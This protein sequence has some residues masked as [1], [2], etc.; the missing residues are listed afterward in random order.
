VVVDSSKWFFA[1]FRL[2][3]LFDLNLILDGSFTQ[4]LDSLR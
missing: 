3:V 4:P 2:Y 1:S